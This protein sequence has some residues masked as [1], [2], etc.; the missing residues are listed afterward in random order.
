ME[1]VYEHQA[2]MYEVGDYVYPT[3][4]PRRHLCRV[5]A[6]NDFDAGGRASQILRLEPLGGPWPAGT[7]LVRLNSAVTPAWR[8]GWR[9]P[10]ARQPVA[11]AGYRKRPAR[12]VG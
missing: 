2:R 7:W 6:A 9:G 12:R 4:L 8:P 10:Q 11:A 3:D 5:T 1:A